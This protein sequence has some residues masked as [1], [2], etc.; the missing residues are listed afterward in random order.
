METFFLLALIGIIAVAYFSWW[1]QT[2]KHEEKEK[3][4][5]EVKDALRGLVSQ[6]P[7]QEWQYSD[8]ISVDITN[9][10]GEA[11]CKE[12]AW[13]ALDKP[14]DEVMIAWTSHP[15]PHVIGDKTTGFRSISGIWNKQN[16]L[17]VQLAINEEKSSITSGR[18][19]GKAGQ[20]LLGTMLFG[21]VGGVVAAS[22]GRRLN[23]ESYE[24][25]KVISL[26]LEIQLSDPDTP[27]VYIHFFFAD[28]DYGKFLDDSKPDKRLS[29]DIEDLRRTDSFMMAQK[30]Y[31]LLADFMKTESTG[32][33]NSDFP[34]GSDVVEQLEK[35]Q[36]MLG[37]G[38]IDKNEYICA[39]AKLL[40]DDPS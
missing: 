24:E 11:L 40:N 14:R 27:Y 36:D 18:V 20:S 10:K 8:S 38:L 32:N 29:V 1:Y 22:G 33:Q 28:I 37:K 39:K 12:A 34:V 31:S 26:A 2:K 23:S 21:A 30:W 19:E 9:K 5:Q 3:V 17:N 16:I 35:L 7:K 25:T 13:L 4:R 6:F 15:Y